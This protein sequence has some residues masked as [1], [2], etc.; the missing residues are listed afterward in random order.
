MTSD[1]TRPA[2]PATD[3][4]PDVSVIIVNWNTRDMLADCIRSVQQQTVARAEVIVIDNCSADGSACMLRELF[5]EVVLIEN[6][7]NR[8]FAQANNQG[9]ALARGDYLL[10]LNPDTIILNHAID[11]MLDW[12]GHHPGVGAVGCQVLEAPGVIQRTCFADPGPLNQMIVELG[13][14][15]LA[16]LTAWFGRPHYLDWDRRSERAVDVITGMFLL[17]PRA[18][19]AKVGP[20]DPGFFVYAEEADWCRR[21]RSAGYAC[22]YAPVA[23]IIHLDGGKKST[24]QVKSKMF[25]QLQKSHIYYVR[26]HS[27]A[28]AARLITSVFVVSSAL[29]LMLFGAVSLLRR[30]P[31]TL[32]RIRLAK[33]A[34]AYHL[35][36]REPLR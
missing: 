15:R 18:V 28:F 33:A 9:L 19:V 27:G 10:L 12:L 30:D 2:K 6:R 4:L 25:V 21:I 11:T 24:Q 32:A 14:M 13:L 29:R 26:K 34:L 16:R 36:G 22:V 17:V 8:G 1:S 20:L 35:F 31:L 23:Q 7:D 3:K 5:P